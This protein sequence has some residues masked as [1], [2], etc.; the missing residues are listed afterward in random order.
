MVVNLTGP[1]Y[2]RKLEN[3]FILIVFPSQNMPCLKRKVSD[4]A[5]P[6]RVL[7]DSFSH[8]GDTLEFI[9]LHQ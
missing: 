3:A 9:L 7:I 5:N 6:F 1:F 4:N 8:R 2:H